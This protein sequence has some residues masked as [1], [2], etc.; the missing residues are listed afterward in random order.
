M[1]DG[2]D[3]RRLGGDDRPGNDLFVKRPQV[4]QRTTAATDDQQ[5]GSRLPVQGFDSGSNFRRR[6]VPLYANRPELYREPS[7]SSLQNTKNIV[8]SRSGRRGNDPDP[9]GIQWQR[10]FPLFIEQ[11]LDGQ[12]LLQ[13]FKCQLQ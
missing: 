11:A 3:D 9:L 7:S 8:D 13:L 12:S 10:L 1:T 2:R 6:P 4:L 5:I